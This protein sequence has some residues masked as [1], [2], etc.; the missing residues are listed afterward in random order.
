MYQI[1]NKPDYILVN[2]SGDIYFKD[3]VEAIQTVISLN[4]YAK[5]NDIWHY[6]NCNYLLSDNEVEKTVGI[7]LEHYPKTRTRH[8]TAIVATSG[9]IRAIASIW[10]E[11][12]KELPYETG[13]FE[14]VKGAE[15]WLKKKNTI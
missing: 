15:I 6:E 1:S 11:Y 8:K 12:A 14:S 4:D 5:K 13:I 10:A 9:F 3:L 7:I 2:L